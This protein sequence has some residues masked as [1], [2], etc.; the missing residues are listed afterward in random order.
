MSV[1]NN[2]TPNSDKPSLF[3]NTDLVNILD[4]L[5]APPCTLLY[6][7]R[8]TDSFCISS[9]KFNAPVAVAPKPFNKSPVSPN[10]FLDSV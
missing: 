9:E 1:S 8:S 2:E 7:A 6:D 4:T 10:S 3:P 5:D